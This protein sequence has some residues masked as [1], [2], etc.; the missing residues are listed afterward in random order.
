[1]AES[2]ALTETTYYI[3]LALVQP[4]HGYGI[5]QVVEEYSQRRIRLAAW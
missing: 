5:M 1:M 4:R 3:L 2:Y